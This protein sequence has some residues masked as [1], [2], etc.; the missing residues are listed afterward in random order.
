VVDLIRTRERVV[1]A[2]HNLGYR[3]RWVQALIGI[4]LSGKVR[5]GGDL[6][7]A[8]I[9][10]FE[11]R[12]NRLNGLVTGQTAQSGDRL[13]PAQQA[14]QALGAATSKG[15][16]DL[17][18]SAQFFDFGLRVRALAEKFRHRFKPPKGWLLG[19]LILKM[20]YQAIL[21]PGGFDGAAVCAERR[22]DD[23]NCWIARP[24]APRRRKGWK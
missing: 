24:T 17:E 2:P 8:K 7:A 21:T 12:S 18:A 13:I 3:V 10:C 4:H 11:S 6:P 9:N 5:I 1:D 23:L 20:A 19:I 16:L 14:P 15:V 22:K